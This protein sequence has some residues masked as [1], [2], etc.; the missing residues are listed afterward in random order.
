MASRIWKLESKSWEK[1]EFG[2]IWDVWVLV[3]FS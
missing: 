3:K 1:V 2:L